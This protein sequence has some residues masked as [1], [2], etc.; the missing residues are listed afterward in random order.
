MNPE[1]RSDHEQQASGQKVSWWTTT[2]FLM[3]HVYFVVFIEELSLTASRA[4]V[5]F[6]ADGYLNITI[7]LVVPMLGYIYFQDDKNTVPT[8]KSSIMKGALSLGMIV[9]QL[10]FGVLGDALGRR[11]IYGKELMITI[12]GTLMVIVMPTSLSHEGVIVWVTMWRLFTGVGI[13]ADYP[14]SST[15]SAEHNPF[16][17]RGKMVLIVFASLGLGNLTAA[18]VFVVLLTAFKGSISDNINRLEWVWRLLLGL[19]IIPAAATLYSRLRMKESIPYERYVGGADPSS[20]SRGLRQQWVEFKEYFSDVKHA[21]VL[22]ATCMTWFLFDIAFYGVN[23]NQS[24]ILSQLGYGKGKTAW[25]TLHNL[26]IGNIIASAAGFM[27]GYYAAIP[28]IDVVGRVRQQF[29]GCILV[30]VIYAFFLNCGPNVTTF[31][32]P[33]EVFPTRVRSTA[34]GISA[35]AGKAGAVLTTFAF[36]SVTEAIGIRG[37]LGILSGVIFLTAL[38]TLMIPETKGKSLDEIENDTIYGKVLRDPQPLRTTD[39]KPLQ[40]Q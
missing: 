36:G 3:M 12:F 7:G 18:I 29:I 28:L 19:G 20:G 1:N 34:H 17:S 11:K 6:F 8:V 25:A 37:V 30:A 16:R 38:L 32:I 35:A 5:G 4:G 2:K 9:G 33:V 23:L 31:L 40:A 27:P 22:F 13:G 14:M 24:I 10:V 26:A 15:L 21:K 39:R